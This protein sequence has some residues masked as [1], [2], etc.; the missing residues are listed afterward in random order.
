[1]RRWGIEAS[2]SG[3]SFTENKTL[4]NED[5]YNSYAVTADYYVTPRL[6]VS[7]GLYLEQD[8][9]MTTYADGLSMKG[10]NMFGPEVGGKF[11]FFPKKWI[12]Q[13]YVSAMLKMN[14][15]N[16]SKQKGQ[17]VYSGKG[18]DCTKANVFYD[19][20]CPVASVAPKLGVDLRL[21]KN[22][23]LTA[24]M[25]YRIGLYGHNRSQIQ[26]LEGGHAGKTCEIDETMVRNGFSIGVKVDLPWNANANSR[27]GN[28][29]MY[30]LYLWIKDRHD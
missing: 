7:G 18:Y 16:L 5:Q 11:Y 30:L 28:N 20:Q 14:V 26:I 3:G 19:V 6:A 21:T 9:M 10:I 17:F 4:L 2:I 13:P 29:L 22:I 25:D 15:L 27:V 12:V 23:I 8:G 1:M 24:N